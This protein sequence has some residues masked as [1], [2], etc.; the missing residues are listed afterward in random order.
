MNRGATLDATFRVL[1][2]RVVR[3]GPGVR[4]G[5]RRPCARRRLARPDS[6][7]AR[8]AAGVRGAV[9]PDA[10][11]PLRSD[12]GRGDRPRPDPRSARI[13]ALRRR[14][15]ARGGLEPAGLGL[16]AGRRA[17]R[18]ALARLRAARR[19]VGERGWTPG[20]RAGRAGIGPRGAGRRRGCRRPAAAAVRPL[21]DRD[22]A[23]PARR[24]GG[25]DP[26]GAGRGSGGQR[27]RSRRR[28]RSSHG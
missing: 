21:P 10:R 20:R 8:R 11:G 26:P 25:V 23:G 4:H 15:A 3:P 16:P 14:G 13:D 22:R 19:P 27:R 12:T 9:D 28:T 2:R 5:D 7:R 17:V 18:V 1:L 6:L 24:G